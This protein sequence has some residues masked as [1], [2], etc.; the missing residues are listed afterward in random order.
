MSAADVP[1][2]AQERLG[3]GAFSSGLSVPEFAACLGMGM[4]PVG[5]VQGFCVMQW[6]WYGAGSMYLR[7]GFGAGSSWGTAISTYNCPHGYVSAE[8]RSWGENFEQT[9]VTQAWQQGFNTA[10]HRMVEE[11]AEAGADGIVGVVDKTTALIDAGVREFHLLGTAVAVDSSDSPARGRSGRGIWTTYLAGQRLAKLLE[12]GFMPVSIAGAMSSIRVWEVCT[13]EILMRGGY[14]NWGLVTPGG[15]IRQVSDAH[16]E[17]RRRAR[18][19]IRS[20]LQGGVLHG[21]EM[22]VSEH[23][24]GEG[25][26]EITCVIRGNAVRPERQAAP[27]EPPLPTV[28][29]Q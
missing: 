1:Q 5:L 3:K 19:Y 27:L 11:A 9:W 12:A 28:R 20:S 13:T 14:D 18:D 24:L 7:S 8:H 23:E 10:Y 21:A 4:R 29:L 17:A 25:D 2:E 15:E 6:S 16:M 22:A 26:R